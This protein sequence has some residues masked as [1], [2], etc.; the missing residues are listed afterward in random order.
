[1]RPNSPRARRVYTDARVED[2][3]VVPDRPARA[4]TRPPRRPSTARPGWRRRRLLALAVLAVVAIAAT[5]S[6]LAR[7][8]QE[9]VPPGVTIGG[10]DVGGMSDAKA[11]EALSRAAAAAIA[12]GVVVKAGGSRPSSLER[13]SESRRTSTRRWRSRTC[14]S[15]RSIACRRVSGWRT[16]STSHSSIAGTTSAFCARCAACAL[17][18]RRSRCRR[19]S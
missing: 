1:M 4:R 18:S 5:G 8:F 17:G 14:N 2:M 13:G 9:A 7:P 19:R 15:S 16:G 10:I 3:V 6:V 11:R 12:R